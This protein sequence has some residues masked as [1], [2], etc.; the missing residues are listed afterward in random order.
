MIRD[1]ETA[2][3]AERGFRVKKLISAKD[4]AL[5]ARPIC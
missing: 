2:E 1:I 3:G 4:E 5:S